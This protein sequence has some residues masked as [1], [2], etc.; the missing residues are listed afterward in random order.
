L[1]RQFRPQAGR[2]LT[3]V[4]SRG[5]AVLPGPA[6]SETE[7]RVRYG[8]EP[9]PCRNDGQLFRPQLENGAM[10]LL[11]VFLVTLLPD[12]IQSRVNLS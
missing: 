10:T 5:A 9:S 8:V 6:R 2:G 3:A 11:C 1:I 12:C 4:V 7:C